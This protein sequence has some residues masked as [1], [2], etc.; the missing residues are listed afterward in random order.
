[1]GARLCVYLLCVRL[2]V[3]W[4]EKESVNTVVFLLS[5]EHAHLRIIVI[6]K[7]VTNVRCVCM[8]MCLFFHQKSNIGMLSV[9]V[10]HI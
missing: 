1:M 4:R 5:L 7:R 2:C 3:H 10:K 6:F 9:N 8:C